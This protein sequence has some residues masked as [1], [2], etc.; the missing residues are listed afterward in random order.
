M[1]SNESESIRAP[2]I[3]ILLIELFSLIARSYL[4]LELIKD[5]QSAALAKNLSYLV[6]PVIWGSMMLPIFKQHRHFLVE[7]FKLTNL[8]LRAVAIGVLVGVL[9]RIA[10]WGHRIGFTA[11]GIYRN[12]DPHAIVGPLFSFSCPPIEIILLH[13]LVMSLLTPVIEEVINR[14]FL[15]YSLLRKGR[16]FAIVLSSV[17]FAAFH[18]PASI[19]GAFIGGLILAVYALNSGSLWA[20]IV[21]HAT[22][23]G[24]IALDWIC[25]QEQWNPPETTPKLLGIGVTALLIGIL[26]LLA[27]SRLVSRKSAGADEL[28]QRFP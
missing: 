20:P 18:T 24:L 28:S 2:I 26:S 5:G 17:I 21:A 27:C 23:N 10:N 19:P 22:Y 3:A 14:G 6:V 7:R 16:L 4:Q 11:L 13:L 25:L 1:Q 12:D 9:L 8:T 15:L